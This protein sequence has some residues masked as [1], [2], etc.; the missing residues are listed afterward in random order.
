VQRVRARRAGVR[1]DALQDLA[2]AGVAG[3]GQR[4]PGDH[5]RL[6]HVQRSP[7]RAQR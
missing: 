3:D 6:E 4:P 7:A 5:P 2:G 1:G